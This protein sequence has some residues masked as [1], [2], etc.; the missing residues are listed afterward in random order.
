MYLILRRTVFFGLLVWL[1]TAIHLS[2]YLKLV[3]HPL[4]IDRSSI[5][6]LLN[7]IH[8]AILTLFVWRLLT[9]V[10]STH[11]GR[12]SGSPGVWR[13]SYSQDY[14]LF[15]W[16]LV[17]LFIEVLPEGCQQ[18]YMMIEDVMNWFWGFMNEVAKVF[19][20]RVKGVCMIVQIS[21][22]EEV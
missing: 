9:R 8:F 6:I 21:S 17:Q 19:I 1:I 16:G 20:E 18:L 14:N 11:F 12:I 2:L 13:R 5:W 22:S 7:R 4:V 15:L 10:H 3:I